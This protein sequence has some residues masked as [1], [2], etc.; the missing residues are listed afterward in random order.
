MLIHRRKFLKKTVDPF[1]GD[2][3]PLPQRT[4]IERKLCSVSATRQAIRLMQKTPAQ[5]PVRCRPPANKTLIFCCITL[6]ANAP[7]ASTIPRT[8]EMDHIGITQMEIH[9]NE[10]L[11]AIPS[12]FRHTERL[13]ALAYRHSG[14]LNT[15]RNSQLL[16]LMLET[17]G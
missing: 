8:E 2:L 5:L 16:A 15:D 14:Q 6:Y 3:K 1:F 10:H 7:G 4:S 17:E 11:I 9:H 12:N 13:N